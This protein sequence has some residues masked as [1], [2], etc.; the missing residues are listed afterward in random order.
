MSLSSGARILGRGMAAGEERMTR[1]CLDEDRS[2]ASSSKGGHLNFS[3]HLTFSLLSKTSLP[4][5][6]G[7][8][9]KIECH[10]QFSHSVSEEW[11]HTTLIQRQGRGTC[12]FSHPVS[13]KG[14]SFT[15]KEGG[16]ASSLNHFQERGNMLL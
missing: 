11:G 6:A 3:I 16:D 7:F 14:P 8:G 5:R 9:N 12:K 1:P 10:S 13:E 4:E 15:L 2:L